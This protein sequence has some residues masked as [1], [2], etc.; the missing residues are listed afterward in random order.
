MQNSREEL[1][2]KYSSGQIS[3]AEL[4]EALKETNEEN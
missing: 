3:Y 1:Y 2:R 4:M